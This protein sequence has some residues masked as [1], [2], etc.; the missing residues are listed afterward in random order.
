MINIR[1][2]KKSDADALL[3]IYTPY[4]HT[5]ISFECDVPSSEEFL[6]RICQ[7]S[8]DYPYLV[9]EVDGNIVGYAYANKFKEREAYQWGAELTVYIDEKYNGKGIGRTFYNAIIDIL[10]L[11]NIKTVYAL[12]TKSNTKSERLHKSLG[13]SIAGIY[14]NTGYKLGEWHD[15]ICFEKT[16]GHYDAVPEKFKSIREINDQLIIDICKKN[17]DILNSTDIN[18]RN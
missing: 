5:P 8:K 17:Q 14:H 10:K 16:I 18:H 11:Q 2:V 7:I 15:V 9:C 1:R 13:F 4:V 6:K 12:V 3:N